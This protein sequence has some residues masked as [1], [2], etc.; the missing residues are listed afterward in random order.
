MIG[1]FLVKRPLSMIFVLIDS[2]ISVQKV[3]LQ[4]LSRL[5]QKERPYTIVFTKSDKVRQKELHVNLKNFVAELQQ[6][7]KNLP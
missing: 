4:F 3:D 7:V 6:H 1:D 5:D 2:S